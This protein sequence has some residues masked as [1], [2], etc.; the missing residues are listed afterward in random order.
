MKHTEELLHT[1][2]GK[3]RNFYTQKLLHTEGLLHTEAFTHRR[4][5]TNIF[6]H[7]ETFT[8]RNVY[9]QRSFTQ[10][11]F[12]TE[13]SLHR[14]VLT[15]RSS[16]TQKLLQKRAFTQRSFYT[17]K[18]Y[19]Q[20]RLHRGVFTH[21]RVCTAKLLQTEVFTQKKPLQRE[22]LT[23][24]TFT[25]GAFTH[26]GWFAKKLLHTETFTQR[27]LMGW[28]LAAYDASTAYLQEK[29][30]DRL[31]ILRAPYP[32]PPGVRPGTLFRAKGGIYGTKDARRSWWKKLAAD[33]KL[34]GCFV[35]PLWWRGNAGRYHGQPRWWADHLR[36]WPHMKRQCPSWARWSTWKKRR[37]SSGIVERML[38][39]PMAPWPS[40]RSTPPRPWSTRW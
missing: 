17:Q 32:P 2:A 21:G 37:K 1:E 9:T 12:Y 18:L 5:Y 14:E 20:T 8:H 19:T 36:S 31:L 28:I 7:T 22:V 11:S 23:K 3:Q 30:I 15:Q 27:S 25:R 38:F 40:G 35:F 4:F 24:K 10:R 26:R 33:A 16:Y 39:K 6:F 13:K 29:G 34:V